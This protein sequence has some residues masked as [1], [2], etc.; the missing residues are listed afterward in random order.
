MRGEV[1]W[2]AININIYQIQSGE[3][4]HQDSPWCDGQGSCTLMSTAL[5]RGGG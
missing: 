1:L 2:W 3:L 4:P 5:G